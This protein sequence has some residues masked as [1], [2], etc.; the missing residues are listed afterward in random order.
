[1]LRLVALKLYNYDLEFRVMVVVTV[2][3]DLEPNE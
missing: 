1:M 2:G 3:K